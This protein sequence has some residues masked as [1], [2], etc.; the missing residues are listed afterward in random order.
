[1]RSTVSLAIRRAVLLALAPA[2]SSGTVTPDA[3]MDAQTVDA[4]TSDVDTS[5]VADAGND[6]DD[7][8]ISIPDVQPP[9][10]CFLTGKPD[11]FAPCGYTEA[12]NDPDVCQ[13]DPNADGGT[14][15]PN[16]CYHLCSWDEPDCYYYE[17]PPLEDGGDA[18]YYL[19]CGAGCIG[20][21]HDDARADA[22]STC[23]HLRA[24]AADFLADAARL[25]A[26]SI[27]A[28]E[29]VARELEAF[30]AP[31]ELVVAA[32]EAA[33][34]EQRHARVVSKLARRRGASVER[35][36]TPDR[37]TRDLRA[38]AIE[39]AIE[40]CVRET[41]G[42]ALATFQA[43]RARASDVRTAMR[44]IARDESSHAALSFRIDA[45]LRARLD[46]AARAELDRARAE[47]IAALE[48]HLA[49]APRRSFD[50]EL[51][52]PPRAEALAML[53]ELRA[54]LWS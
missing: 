41:Y 49:T 17:L 31:A 2:C 30:G 20:R 7:S 39:N 48:S 27:D 45:W 19:T 37:R 5:D 44:E 40:G 18:S 11:G 52:L 12:L 53:N 25:E 9:P 22:A 28:F 13:V 51:G 34:E 36:V 14:Q 43:S 15:D 26:A 54:S 6:I 1:M 16:V 35:P 42:A 47:A 38:F 50:D 32:R 23:A 8:S 4:T 3:G 10:G 29:I 46:D 21:L 24:T 33:R